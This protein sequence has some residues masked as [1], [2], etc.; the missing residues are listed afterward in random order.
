[1]RVLKP[2]PS[3]ALLCVLLPTTGELFE[4]VAACRWAVTSFINVV[5][6]GYLAHVSLRGWWLPCFGR[7]EVTC[8]ASKR[9]CKFLF[10]SLEKP[11]KI[12]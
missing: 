1:M 2:N 10:K 8:A 12:G 6:R 3:V 9:V 11:K 7:H 5:V 4:H